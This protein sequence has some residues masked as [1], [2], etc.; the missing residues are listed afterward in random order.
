MN[1]ST[2]CNFMRRLCLSL[3]TVNECNLKQGREEIC[4]FAVCFFQHPIIS[5]KL[6][7]AE[8]MCRAFL[9]C[10]I[11]FIERL[12]KNKIFSCVFLFYCQS[13][14]SNTIAKLD[15]IIDINCVKTV[16]IDNN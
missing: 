1:V 15:A 5:M 10:F 8:K 14:A 16:K 2:F 3:E 13:I 12:C 9:R 4:D 7:L 6:K 11:E